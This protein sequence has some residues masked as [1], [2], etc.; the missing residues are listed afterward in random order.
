MVC[1]H[2]EREPSVV[3]VQPLAV[4]FLNYHTGGFVE[5][6]VRDQ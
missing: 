4:S 5:I 3:I 1:P 6:C 2:Y